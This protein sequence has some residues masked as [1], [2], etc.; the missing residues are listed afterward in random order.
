MLNRR[1]AICAMTISCFPKDQNGDSHHMGDLKISGKE[2]LSLPARSKKYREHQ[3]T[4]ERRPQG[5][6]T[7]PLDASEVR[8]QVSQS[9]GRCFF[10]SGTRLGALFLTW[11]GGWQCG[12]LAGKKNLR[13]ALLL[14]VQATAGRLFFLSEPWL[15][16]SL[17]RTAVPTSLNWFVRAWWLVVL[18]T[19]SRGM[20]LDLNFPEFGTVW[21]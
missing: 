18:V 20:S 3:H 11:L 15:H 8:V 1:Q 13:R 6:S 10:S 17:H 4:S 21:V 14:T 9:V 5:S 7:S 2:F 12:L 16:C 19:F